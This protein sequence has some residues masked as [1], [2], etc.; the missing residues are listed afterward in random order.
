VNVRLTAEEKAVLESKAKNR[1]LKGLS[2]FLRAA[3]LDAVG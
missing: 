2:A 3:A 1:G